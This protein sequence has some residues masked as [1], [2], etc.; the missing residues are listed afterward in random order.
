MV[1]PALSLER[2]VFL[3]R[4]YLALKKFRVVLDEISPSSPELVQPLKMLAN[5]LAYP[6][7]R[8]D[9]VADLDSKVRVT[10]RSDLSSVRL[11]SNAHWTSHFLQGTRKKAIF[12]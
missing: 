5:F 9:I 4:S 7:K 12:Y 6:A 11:Y 2:D 10:S 8:D 3:Y 1:D